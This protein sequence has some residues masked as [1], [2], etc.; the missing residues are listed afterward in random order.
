[1]GKVSELF[2]DQGLIDAAEFRRWLDETNDQV[3]KNKT[4]QAKEV[5]IQTQTFFVTPSEYPITNARNCSEDSIGGELVEQR[6][7]SYIQ[8]VESSLHG[9]R[10]PCERC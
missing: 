9:L 3:E 1:M 4:Q 5:S 2:C 8:E 6:K 10:S 7:A